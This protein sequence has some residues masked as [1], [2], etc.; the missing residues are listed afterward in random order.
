[1]KD[2]YFVS[3][4]ES[5]ASEVNAVHRELGNNRA[6]RPCNRRIWK[7]KTVSTLKGPWVQGSNFYCT[8]QKFSVA[9][10]ERCMRKVTVFFIRSG[11]NWQGV[12]VSPLRQAA[13]SMRDHS[14]L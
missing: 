5:F 1:M 9:N 2:K 4:S 11:Q 8:Q 10:K 12:S 13:A 6:R 14:V 7:Q 3:P